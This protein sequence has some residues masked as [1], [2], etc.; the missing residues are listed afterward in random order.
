MLEG[1][2]ALFNTFLNA[3]G[4]LIPKM[5]LVDMTIGDRNSFHFISGDRMV[6]VAWGFGSAKG[7]LS[8]LILVVGTFGSIDSFS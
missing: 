3:A 1:T 8:I 7:K 5:N 2:V 6:L 4:F